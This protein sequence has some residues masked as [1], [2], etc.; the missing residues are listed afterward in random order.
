M[1]HPVSDADSYESKTE[2]DA[3]TRPWRNRVVL[4]AAITAVALLVIAMLSSGFAK[5]DTANSLPDGALTAEPEMV[6]PGEDPA[7]E[8]SHALEGIV[9][10]LAGGINVG[11]LGSLGVSNPELPINPPQGDLPL[12]DDPMSVSVFCDVNGQSTLQVAGVAPLAGM[13]KI[14][15]TPEPGLTFT[16]LHEYLEKGQRVWLVEPAPENSKVI[17]ALQMPAQPDDTASVN[18]TRRAGW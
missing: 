15:F 1:T 14:T 9:P 17:V 2:Y 10:L 3:R 5:A 11:S 12:L 6:Y 18:S 13:Y 4:W 16:L 7:E 8:L